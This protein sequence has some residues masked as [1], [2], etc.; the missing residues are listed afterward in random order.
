MSKNIWQVFSVCLF[1]MSAQSTGYDIYAHSLIYYFNFE[2]ITHSYLVFDSD[3][4][5]P[6][7]GLLSIVYELSRN[8]GIPMG[9]IAC[10]L[11]FL[12]LYNIIY[13]FG[14][15]KVVFERPVYLII[16]LTCIILIYFYSGL[17]LV[18]LWLLAFLV[19]GRVFFIAGSFF[20]PVGV[21]L[22][23]F[24]LFLSPKR[25]MAFCYYLFFSSLLIVFMSVNSCC[26]NIMESINSN[27][28]KFDIN[29]ND[30][31]ELLFYSYEVKANEMNLLFLILIF[32][33]LFKIFN[34]SDDWQYSKIIRIRV[35]SIYT[36]SIVSTLFLAII[37]NVFI[38]DI[39][40]L[41]L[42]ILT[43]NLTDSIYITWFD[44]GSRNRDLDVWLVEDSRY[45]IISND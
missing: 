20:H 42:S 30:L 16:S 22:G 9:W 5:F 43:F 25:W 7:Y 36:K 8:L 10:F 13:K 27:N 23:L 34:K 26:Y 24:A 38:R 31:I 37:L 15:W 11:V 4:L 32:I 14:S 2:K 33:I 35:K 21:F 45:T 39:N 3:I 17:S 29:F 44:F 18:V 19:T 1:L 12:P 40:S 41:L 28:V 6:R